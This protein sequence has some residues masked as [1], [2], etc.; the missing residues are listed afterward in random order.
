MA[1]QDVLVC[2]RCVRLKTLFCFGL[3][4]VHVTA[5]VWTRHLR[6]VCCQ[7]NLQYHPAPRTVHTPNPSLP[8]ILSFFFR[9]PFKTGIGRVRWS[10]YW[11]RWVSFSRCSQIF[12]R[13][14]QCKCF[15]DLHKH[16]MRK[17]VATEYYGFESIHCVRT[18]LVRPWGL[19][20]FA[21]L[22]SKA[23]LLT[24][25][26]CVLLALAVC[27]ERQSYQELISSLQYILFLKKFLFLLFIF[28]TDIVHAD[29]QN[30]KAAGAWSGYL[31]NNNV[32]RFVV[33]RKCVRVCARARF[34]LRVYCL[35]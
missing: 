24:L 15:A 14:M 31:I 22:L 26:V 35:Y 28:I 8:P 13:I 5:E 33:V 16:F 3:G 12:K 19:A 21:A 34:R 4:V 30:I 29:K 27:K 20:L 32:S 7:R 2:R 6:S 23:A 11:V 25:F 17:E 10:S 9:C 1:Q 18:L